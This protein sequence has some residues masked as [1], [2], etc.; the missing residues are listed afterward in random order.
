MVE[1]CR[2][3]VITGAASGMGA[4]SARAFAAG[5]DEVV[6]IDRDSER[7]FAVADSIAASDP[8]I[9]DV[10]DSTFCRETL[11]RVIDTHGRIDVLVNCAGTI[12]RANAL[13]TDDDAWRR[14]M[15]VNVDGTFF[16]CRAA[17]PH[18]PRCGPG[19]DR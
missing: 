19:R 5:G 3:V 18:M 9:G 13:G 15:R 8:I 2:V 1:P 6:I 16:M 12:H 17:I 11:D 10:S 4:A 7:A 14:V